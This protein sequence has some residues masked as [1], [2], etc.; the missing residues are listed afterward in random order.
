MIIYN[1]TTKIAAALQAEWL[2]WMRNTHIPEVMAT[3]CFERF[4]LTQLIEDEKDD[5]GVTYAVQFYCPGKSDLDQYLNNHAP[6]LRQ[7][8]FAAWGNQFISF[9]TVMEILE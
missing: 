5:D 8:A 1:V 6:V 7:A 2:Q 9:R 4:Q 3:Q